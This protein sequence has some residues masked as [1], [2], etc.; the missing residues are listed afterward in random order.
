[1]E[2]GGGR[3]GKKLYKM[4]RCIKFISEMLAKIEKLWKHL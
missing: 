1:M 2:E 3:L 4:L